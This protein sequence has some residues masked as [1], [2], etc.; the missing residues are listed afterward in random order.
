[1]R[2]I[3][4]HQAQ[5]LQRPADVFAGQRM[6][7]HDGP[8]FVGQ[9]RSLFQN[10]IGNRDLPQ[11]MQISAPAQRHNRFFI[12]A[13][14]PSQVAGILRQAFA[15]AFGIGIAALHAQAQRAQHRLRCFQFVGELLELE[16][17]LDPG[18]QFLGE[19]RLV[20]KVVGARL[21]SPQLVSRDRSGR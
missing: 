20:Q 1:M 9:I 13:E 21:D 10:V 14:M 15:V 18:K 4:K 8:F 16:Q 2:I 6:L 19:N 17:R 7:L 5:R 12:Q 3:G 11:V